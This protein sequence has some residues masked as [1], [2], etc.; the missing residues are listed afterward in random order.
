[1]AFNRRLLNEGEAISLDLKPHWW[2]FSKNILTGIPLLIVIVLVTGLDGSSRTAT[3]SI[4]GIATLLWAIWLGLQ[5]VKWHLTQF[6]VTDR[7]VIFRTGVIRRHGV[8]VPL[9]RI[10][11]IVFHQG[12]FERLIGAGDLVVES[13]GESGQSTFT[14]VQHPDAVQQEINRLMELSSRARA[15]RAPVASPPAAN[16]DVADQIRKLAALRDDGVIT[17]DDYE[18][19]KAELL[20]R[21]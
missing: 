8:E 19:K 16:A 20:E 3:L 18:T 17:A 7:R 14:D 4:W 12:L 2:F 15:V 1:M 13:A 6:V 9:Q 10:N 21:M 11:N 5:Y